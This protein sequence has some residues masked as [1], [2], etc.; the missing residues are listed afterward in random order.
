MFCLTSV[1]V[2]QQAK[3]QRQHLRLSTQPSQ[4]LAQP[5]GD[6]QQHSWQE[7]DT[8][9]TMLTNLAHSRTMASKARA[10]GMLHHHLLNP[11]LK[12]LWR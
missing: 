8:F 5:H 1:R 3:V 6:Q 4:G 9:T 2:L 10:V 12:H 11:M 7:A